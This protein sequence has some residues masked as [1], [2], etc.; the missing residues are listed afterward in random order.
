[1]KNDHQIINRMLIAD[2]RG[3]L[4][5][6]E[7]VSEDFLT[8]SV[9]STLNYLNPKWLEKFLSQSIN[10]N[11]NKL[12]VNINYP[13]YE[14][15]PW[16]SNEKKFGGVAEP[17]L[18]IYSEDLAIIIEAKNYSGKSGEGIIIN[19]DS[20]DYIADQLGREY[21]VGLK[22]LLGNNIRYQNKKNIRI[23]KIIV[24]Y[25]TRHNLFP[26][27]D[28]KRSLESIKEID[29]IEYI[30]A[31]NNI[32]WLNWNEIIPILED[33]INTSNECD[34]ENKISNDL[35]NFLDRRDIGLFQG[36]DFKKVYNIDLNNI[37]DH[38]FYKA[39]MLNYW[40]TIVFKSLEVENK[41]LFYEKLNSEYWNSIARNFN[42]NKDKTLFYQGGK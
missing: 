12:S 37:K 24:I 2:I 20:E 41:Y 35:L 5:L 10:I 30:N 17:D 40:G 16:I 13:I 1:M 25:L 26:V 8:S 28:I 14:F 42:L 4:N 6:S 33:I 18:V 39:Q 21:F 7:L 9:F 22:K 34:S 27:K 29:K 32:Y 31:V 11:K 38:I 23:D 3:E 19:E 36:F 15:W